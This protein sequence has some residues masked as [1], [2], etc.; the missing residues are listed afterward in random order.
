[1]NLL[2]CYQL[3]LVMFDEWEEAHYFQFCAIEK[4]IIFVNMYGKIDFNHCNS[5]THHNCN[6]YN[7]FGCNVY[8]KKHFSNNINYYDENN[9]K[10]PCYQCFIWRLRTC[11]LSRGDN[12]GGGCS[13]GDDS[14]TVLCAVGETCAYFKKVGT[15]QVNSH[16]QWVNSTK[17]V[18]INDTRVTPLNRFRDEILGDLPESLKLEKLV[19]DAAIP[20]KFNFIKMRSNLQSNDKKYQTFLSYMSQL[21]IE[22]NNF[23]ELFGLIVSNV[24]E[25]L[26]SNF[27]FPYIATQVY[28]DK[29]K[30]S[31]YQEQLMIAEMKHPQMNYYKYSFEICGYT[32]NCIN[33]ASIAIPN[34]RVPCQLKRIVCTY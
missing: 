7:K 32:L 28:I 31:I 2:S 29:Y 19:F 4:E 30:A 18:R 6:R 27:L 21:G 16:H 8:N 17:P 5:L 1:M 9:K 13:V 14:E 3:V 10:D 26:K 11:D 33:T 20:L 15:H 22:N 25:T 12:H 23:D 34:S 24:Y